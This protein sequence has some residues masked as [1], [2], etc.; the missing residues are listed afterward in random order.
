MKKN[1]WLIAIGASLSLAGVAEASNQ[2]MTEMAV[3]MMKQQG[4]FSRIATCTGVSESKVENAARKV[5]DSCFS[6]VSMDDEHAMNQC[7]QAKMTK[8]LGVSK[9]KMDSC[10]SEEERQEEAFSSNLA[11]LEAQRDALLDEESVLL[12]KERLTSKQ[13]ARLAQISEA[14]AALDEEAGNMEW[15][16]EKVSM[17]DS[18]RK[19]AQLME[20]R[21]E[22]SDAQIKEVE[23]LRKA[24]RLEQMDDMQNTMEMMAKASENTL[25]VITLPIY[26]NSEVMM[27]MPMGS[28]GFGDGTI[29]T[30]PAASFA[31]SDSVADVVAFYKKAL[32]KFKQKNME[33]G[34]VVFM[35]SMPDG[36]DLLNN[37]ETYTQTPHV[38]VSEL[39]S[40][41]MG[42][43]KGAKT[44]IEIA[45][46]A[47]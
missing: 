4:E 12:E 45:Y 32:A 13:Q 41:A 28:M 30:L 46:R 37:F 18:E 7:M 17:S 16:M 24:I 38:T 40:G 29:Q 25:D 14:L 26:P 8:A 27:H 6:S 9:A 19:L 23:K 33:T 43:S 39:P 21:G 22:L 20:N 15:E 36:F 31:S 35:E 44:M 10:K 5:M 11:K 34:Q 1:Q 42:A 47:K 3:S 2:A